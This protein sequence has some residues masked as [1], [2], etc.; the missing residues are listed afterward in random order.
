MITGM[1]SGLLPRVISSPASVPVGSR[2][3]VA[4]IDISG[5]TNAFKASASVVW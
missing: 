5:Y 1:G 3:T 2:A 4:S